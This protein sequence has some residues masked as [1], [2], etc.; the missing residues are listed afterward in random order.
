LAALSLMIGSTVSCT[1][2]FQTADQATEPATAIKEFALAPGQK[3]AGEVREYVVKP[4]EG[5]NEIARKFDLGYTALAAANPGVGQF[6]PGVGRRLI[7]PSLYVL[8]D[9]PLHGI[10]INLAQYRLFYFPPGG[11]RVVTYPVGLAVFG[12]KTPLGTTSIVRKEPHPTWYPPPSIRA[13]R[14]ELPAMISPGPDNPLGEYAMHLGWPRYLIHG[15]NKPDG[16][17]R[18]VSHG[19]IRMYPED[20]ERLFS[21]LSIGTPVRTV[22]Q[23]TTA[24]W[25]GD[26]L[27][28]KI[29]PSKT[30]TEEID[31]A[32]LVRLEP[33][34]GA[35]NVVRAAAGRYSDVVDWRAVDKAALERT[36]APVIV[37][38]RSTSAPGLGKGQKS[39]DEEA[40]IIRP[41]R[42]HL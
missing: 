9:A 12:S 35:R 2:S 28:L 23:P 11:G 21:E 33:A 19:C 31:T 18:N 25:V 20:I 15:T 32:R 5:L 36:G 8:P 30:Q 14:P 6:A 3:V 34:S 41:V 17:G 39:E 13:E 27:Y 29:Y 1:A 40:S 26:R 22:N 37:A 42:P 4:G 24:G 16:V 38:D 10:V 7:I